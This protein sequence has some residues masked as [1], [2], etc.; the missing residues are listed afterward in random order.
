MN[1]DNNE[2]LSSQMILETVHALSEGTNAVRK[3]I[4]R[5]LSFDEKVKD[6]SIYEFLEL[7]LDGQ[8]LSYYDS[9]KLLKIL[10]REFEYFNTLIQNLIGFFSSG[11]S[12]T[13]DR[14]PTDIKR[15]LEEI[16]SLF[17]GLAAEKKLKVEL[18]VKGDPVLNIDKQQMR[19]AFIN[20]IDNAIKYSY[21]SVNDE[22]FIK[23]TCHRHSNRNDWLI[24]FDSY[25][26]GITQEEIAD[27]SIFQYGTRGRLSGDRGRKGTG[28]GLAETKR[29]VDAHN[30]KIIVTSVNKGA[31]SYLTSM[32]IILPFGGGYSK[33]ARY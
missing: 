4:E 5:E 21:F 32:K 8:E 25:G 7:K 19:R 13:L 26:V 1:D 3:S 23:I 20:L 33:N 2:N 12:L 11:Q 28:I 24:S 29:I 9:A 15:L 6:I 16:I 30:G 10:F 17:E 22:R 27:G 14:T 18:N 31:D